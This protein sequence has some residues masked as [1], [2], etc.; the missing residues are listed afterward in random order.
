MRS[1]GDAP[2]D[3]NIEKA[4]RRLEEV[5]KEIRAVK[6]AGELSDAELRQLVAEKR[7]EW[8]A[9][10]QAKAERILAEA[11]EIADAL[12]RKLSE[13][14]GLAGVRTWLTSGGQSYQP[15][16][17]VSLSPVSTSIGQLLHERR[18]ELGLLDVEV[19]G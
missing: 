5:D 10:V 8:D 14:E 19:I 13:T 15:L 7:Y 6:H 1:G 18:R 9:E 12:T 3:K 11:A 16:S 17:P 2:T 4:R